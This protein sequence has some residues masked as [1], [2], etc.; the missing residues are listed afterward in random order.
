[1]NK[2]LGIILMLEG[3][4]S[5][6]LAVFMYYVVRFSDSL[7]I[8]SLPFDLIGRGLRW[9]SLSSAVGNIAAFLLYVAFSLIPLIYLAGKLTRRKFN[10]SDFLLP[11]LSIY[12]F[13]MMYEFINPDLMLNRTFAPLLDSSF[14][15]MIKLSFS[16]LFYTFLIAYL[17]LNMISHLS[18]SSTDN[19][20]GNLCSSLSRI[21]II[22]S[23]LY[24][25]FISYFISFELFGNIDKYVI[26]NRKPINLYYLIIDYVLEALPI[27]FSVLTLLSGV[28]LLMAM[29]T[30]HMKE[31]EFLAAKKMSSISKQAV[32]VTVLCNIAS[33]ALQFL[34]SNVLN[35]T[36]FNLNISLAPLVI[37]FLAMILSGYFKESM[38]LYD[39][40]NMII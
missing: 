2:K 10:K 39:D 21:L 17:I 36:N 26:E 37:A 18:D 25:V 30:D 38:E 7:F 35:D 5:F 9:L 8:L 31:K 12:S 32:Y 16:F 28:G 19:K 23:G 1:M 4:L 40:N 24:T 15:P 13:Y 11:I 33:N 6:C 27:L 14:V 34:L 3:V 20:L 29:V 22:L